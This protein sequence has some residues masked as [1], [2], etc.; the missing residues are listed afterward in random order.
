MAHAGTEFWLA[1]W[2]DVAPAVDP[3]LLIS[4][5]EATSGHAS[6]PGLG[7]TIPFTVTPGELTRVTIP[8]AATILLSDTVA[9]VGIRVSTQHPVTL[10]TLG[11]RKSSVN[12]GGA[13]V[14]PSALLGTHYHLLGWGAGVLGSA[15]IIAA[16]EDST[17]LTITP[18]V[19]FGARAAGVPYDIVLQ[20]GQAYLMASASPHDLS[21]SALVSN[22]PVAVFGGNRCANVPFAEIPPCDAVIEQ[23]MPA[24]AF[25][26]RF[27]TLPMPGRNGG[28]IIRVMALEDGTG[29]EVDGAQ[30]VQL[31]KGEVYDLFR[32][33]PTRITTSKPAA[34][35][36]F[37][38]SN[39]LDVPD[40]DFGDPLMLDI[41][42]REQW[43][44]RWTASVARR[45]FEGNIIY[46]LTIIAPAS[47]I[48][49]IRVDGVGVSPGSFTVIGDGLV[50]AHVAVPPGTYRVTAP[51]P[52]S[53]SVIG[54]GGAEAY[55][56]PAGGSPSGLDFDG[57]DLVARYR[58]DG[59][60]DPSFGTAGIAFIDH[61]AGFGSVLPSFDIARTALVEGGEVL[62]ASASTNGASGQ[63]LFV[64]YRL[65]AGAIFR[66][67][68]E[69]EATP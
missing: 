47:A 48:G 5:D 69:A 19:G 29:V 43:Q 26:L 65:R 9:D 22:H 64:A 49:D 60:R 66:D 8:L 10:H 37:A 55:G 53:V 56:Y 62:V 58:A 46:T 57:D 20:R 50:G 30:P 7:L 44:A 15:F 31:S 3:E 63:R 59:A 41:L 27:A 23:Q 38:S 1:M 36:Q 25:G 40:T 35:A 52:I 54:T 32:L 4:A 11:G 67:G 42:P 6:L 51:V 12:A 21:G 39:N 2:E 16:S 18:T 45:E 14:T 17:T 13:R 34:V 61:R 28:D 33:V 24:S 68:F